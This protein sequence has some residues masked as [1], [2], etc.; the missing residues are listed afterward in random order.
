[1][2]AR[3][4][5]V[6]KY[7]DELVNDKILVARSWKVCIET[8]FVNDVPLFRDPGTLDMTFLDRQPVVWPYQFIQPDH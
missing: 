5:V 1:M 6:G 4:E 3:G 7:P 2:V 8:I